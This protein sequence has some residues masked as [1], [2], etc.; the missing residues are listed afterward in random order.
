MAKKPYEAAV[1]AFEEADGRYRVLEEAFLSGDFLEGMS[2]GERRTLV[3]TKEFFRAKLKELQDAMEERNVKRREA[4]DLLRQAV[5]LSVTKWRGPEG[6]PT[7]LNAGPFKVSSVTYRGFD[8]KSLF[9]MC[10]KH[11]VLERLMEL[12][13]TDKDGKEKK[14]VQLSYDIDFQGVLSWLKANELNDVLDGAYDEKEGTPQVK[15]PKEIAFLV[16]K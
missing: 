11:G 16:E 8:Q 6:T 1:K 10:Q 5:T 2:A 7:L 3:A 9:D 15:G 14:L 12:K 13:G 4:A